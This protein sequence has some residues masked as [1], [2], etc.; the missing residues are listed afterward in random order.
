[1]KLKY[2][3]FDLPFCI[4]FEIKTQYRKKDDPKTFKDRLSYFRA[5]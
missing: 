5:V 4:V 2:W 1:M 3:L